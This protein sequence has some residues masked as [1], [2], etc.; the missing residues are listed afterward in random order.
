MG[1]VE[2]LTQHEELVVYKLVLSPARPRSSE[3]GCLEG[4][5]DPERMSSNSSQKQDPS[6]IHLGDCRGSFT[7]YLQ[8]Q[9]DSLKHYHQAR[10]LS[11]H[12]R[13]RVIRLTGHGRASLPAL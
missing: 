10:F 7:M 13:S 6:V 11:T 3:E 2:K 8:S 12:I 5:G 9:R 4:T 1:Q